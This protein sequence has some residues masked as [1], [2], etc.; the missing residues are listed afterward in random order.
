MNRFERASIF[1]INA[2]IFEIVISISLFQM[3]AKSEYIEWRFYEN[4]YNLDTKQFGLAR[5]CP[6]LS[7]AH[8]QL[9]NTA[10]MR[11]RLATQVLFYTLLFSISDNKS[12]SNIMNRC[13]T[14]YYTFF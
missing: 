5:V 11:V 9:D 13:C 8:I 6:K 12:V 14:E 1:K 3:N 10:K 2:L 7:K 4:L